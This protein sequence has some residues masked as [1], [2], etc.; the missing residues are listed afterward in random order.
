MLPP[1]AAEKDPSK[2]RYL[3]ADCT[4]SYPTRAQPLVY[5]NEQRTRSGL[6]CRL[7]R[8]VGLPQHCHSYQKQRISKPHLRLALLLFCD[9]WHFGGPLPPATRNQKFATPDSVTWCVTDAVGIMTRLL[10]YVV[11]FI[12]GSY[13][14]KEG[15][16]MGIF[17]I[18]Q[19]FEGGG[20]GGGLV[21]RPGPRCGG[22][23]RQ[24]GVGL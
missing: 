13:C 11:I 5:F 10:E 15:E 23:S 14:L 7:T 16:G 4:A 6:C 22:R 20:V 1:S 9:V 18:R 3:S 24:F 19:Q 8:H 12:A 2:R 17:L 21:D